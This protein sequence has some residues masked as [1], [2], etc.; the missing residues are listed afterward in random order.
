MEGPEQLVLVA[1]TP[2]V[3]D[4]GAVVCSSIGAYA[5][6]TEAESSSGYQPHRDDDVQPYSSKKRRPEKGH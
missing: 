6:G 3:R 5:R 2:V 4:Q 1:L